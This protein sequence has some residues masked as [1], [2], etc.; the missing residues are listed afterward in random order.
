MIFNPTDTH[1]F[2][3][4]TSDAAGALPCRQ[5]LANGARS[6]RVHALAR[7]CAR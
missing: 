3:P 7:R 5:E 2:A 4:A 1:M 6:D